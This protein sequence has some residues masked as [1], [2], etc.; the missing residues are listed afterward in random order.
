VTLGVDILTINLP[1]T[2]IPV[3]AKTNTSHL[4]TLIVRSNSKA[5]ATIAYSVVTKPR[6]KLSGIRIPLD[7][8]T[9]STNV[10]FNGYWGTFEGV[11]LTECDVHLSIPFSAKVKHMYRYSSTPLICL[12]GVERDNLF[13]Y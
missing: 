11:R 9:F 10:Q 6:N 13:Y 3:L 4:R 5:A 1:T 7:T 12:H 8:Q 2:V